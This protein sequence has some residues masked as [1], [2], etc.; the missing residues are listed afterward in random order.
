[1][2]SK[3]G[4]ILVVGGG[5]AGMTAAREL[6]NS[7]RKVYLLER[8]PTI[9]GYSA[10]FSCKAAPTCSKCSVCLVPETM[11]EVANNP[12]I[13]LMVNS[14]LAGLAGQA[15][16]FTAEVVQKPAFVD[17]EKC[18]ACGVCQDVCP[19]QPAAIHLPASLTIP[20]AYVIDKKRCL[21]LKG[22]Q[23]NACQ[24]KCPTGAIDL[25]Q[26][27]KKTQLTASAVIVATGFDVFDARSKGPLGY[28][29]YSNVL[30]G[31]D[32]ETRLSTG[33]PFTLPS[34]G[35]AASDVAFVQCVGS[36]DEYIG[37]GY[38][39]QVCC[40]Y[41]IR[42]AKLLKQQNPEAKITI[43]YMDL[44]TGGKGFAEF[45]EE[46]KDT[47]RFVRGVPVEVSQVSPDKLEVRYEDLAKSKASTA[48]HDLVVLSVGI[49]SRQDSWDVAKVLGINLGDYRFF[50]AQDQMDTAQTNVEGIFLAGTCQGPKDVPESV[51][52]GAQAALKAIQ[53]LVARGN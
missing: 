4:G 30:T 38:C 17:P 5:I 52:H 36:R 13:S 9:G 11:L 32:L 19:A 25:E 45:F 46:C 43:Y 21:R 29:R 18:T 20:R 48:I 44:Q 42:F 3:N 47:F 28:G 2:K 7:N 35:K 26:A 50:G 6:A 15:G 24:A 39:S 40:K 8:E 27:Q 12:L 1:M 23:C 10:S 31:L 33:A 53:T 37:N 34:N 22:E 51:A 14:E 49:S 41:A 16:D